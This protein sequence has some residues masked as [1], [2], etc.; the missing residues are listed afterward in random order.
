[1]H[2][3]IGSRVWSVYVL[4]GAF[5]KICCYDMKSIFNKSILQS[6]QN[7]SHCFTINYPDNSSDVC[8]C[9]EGLPFKIALFQI[10]LQIINYSF[11]QHQRSQYSFLVVMEFGEVR[12]CLLC[13]GEAACT[14]CHRTR[15]QPKWSVDNVNL[16]VLCF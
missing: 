3:L 11:V 14:T 13:F 16:D 7:L 4:L 12:L 2:W 6:N 15:V 9:T 8:P 1:M 10:D 5:R